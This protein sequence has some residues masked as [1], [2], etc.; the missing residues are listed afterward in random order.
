DIFN[1]KTYAMQTTS[2]KRT[3]LNL[4]NADYMQKAGYDPA[5]KPM[6]WSDFRAAAKKIT[7]QGQGKYYGVII[8]GSQASSWSGFLNDLGAL[9]GAAGG[10]FNWKRC[11]WRT[12]AV[13]R[14]QTATGARL[15]KAERR[16]WARGRSASHAATR[17]T[18]RAVA[19][20]RCNRR[21]FGR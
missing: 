12:S 21:V 5:G 15:A 3:T 4:Y 16:A 14:N 19:M 10:E 7:E 8:G 6:T 9:A 11:C 2:P 20:S 13:G 1:G 18:F 17:K